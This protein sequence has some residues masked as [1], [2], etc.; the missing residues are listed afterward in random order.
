LYVT[1]KNNEE[2]DTTFL[3]Q[4]SEEEIEDV[5]EKLIDLKEYAAPIED[6][7]GMWHVYIDNEYLYSTMRVDVYE[8]VLERYLVDNYDEIEKRLKVEKIIYKYIYENYATPFE[9][10]SENFYLL[11]LK[12]E[13]KQIILE[14][15]KAQ[16]ETIND[17]F[18]DEELIEM[19]QTQASNVY[20]DKALDKILEETEN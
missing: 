11:W 5:K 10:Y 17:M 20:N 18:S 7:Y 3:K 1:K 14:G 2:E 9:Y 4:L 15:I 8:E 13:E 19:I 6:I 16:N 12:E